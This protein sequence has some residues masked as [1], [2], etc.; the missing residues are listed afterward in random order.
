MAAITAGNVRDKD[1]YQQLERLYLDTTRYEM[2][3]AEAFQAMV[4]IDPDRAAK[5]VIKEL[6]SG[7][8]VFAIYADIALK[9]AY[10]TSLD[11]MIENRRQRYKRGGD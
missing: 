7:K 4:N 8:P 11:A 10:G 5:Y 3:R 6:S 9:E 2:V 1:S